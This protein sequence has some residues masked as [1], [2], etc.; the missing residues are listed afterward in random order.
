M[1]KQ[2]RHNEMY[3]FQVAF[4]RNLKKL[5]GKNCCVNDSKIHRLCC[6]FY[7]NNLV[8]ASNMITR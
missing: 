5:H 3:S 7:Y 8:N 4:Q 2:R 6:K 1:K